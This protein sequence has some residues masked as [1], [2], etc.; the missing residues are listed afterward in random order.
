VKVD[1]KWDDNRPGEGKGAYDVTAEVL[2][3]LQVAGGLAPDAE[4]VVYF[5][6]SSEQG[7]TDAV[8][9]AV[10][11]EANDLTVLLICYGQSRRGPR[12]GL[13]GPGC[14]WT[15][16]TGLAAA[17]LRGI[18]VVTSCGDNGG[19]GAPWSTRVHADFPAAQPVGAQLRRHP[20]RPLHA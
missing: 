8:W 7:L 12:T 16:W 2:L 10:T 18:T 13:C 14:A 9:R 11:D 6:E 20:G 17:A 3:D 1:P 4:Y 15:S 19:A 5:S